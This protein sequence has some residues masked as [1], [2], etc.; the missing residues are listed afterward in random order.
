M[1]Y[2]IDSIRQVKRITAGIALLAIPALP[3]FAQT[4]TYPQVAVAGVFNNFDTFTPNMVLVA[5]NL[6]QADL[7][8]T[9]KFFWFKFAT[10]NFTQN[11]G[12]N[13]QPHQ[14][15][16]QSENGAASANDIYVTNGSDNVQFRFIFDETS[17]DY[18]VF[19]VNNIGSNLIYNSS[20]E[21]QGSSQPRAKYW[22][23]GNP[24]NHG[25]YS[26]NAQRQGS[27]WGYQVK[28]GAWLGLIGGT[29]AG[30]DNGAWWQEVPVEPGLTYEA[31]GWFNS[32]VGV[33][34]TW[35]TA[36]QQELKLE[37][38]NF[39]R[40]TLLATF[41]RDL[42]SV[43]NIWAEHAVAGLAPPGA[44]WAR[45]VFYATGVG[46]TGTLRMDD[47]GLRATV[48]KRSEDF[49]D[50]QGATID[51]SYT[52][53]GWTLATGRTVTAYIYSN[54]SISLARSGYAAS[55]SNPT[56]SNNGSFIQT[57]RFGDGVG[58]IS[59][60]YRH[61]YQG[62][63]AEN[64]DLPVHFKVQYS[65][66]GDSWVTIAQV[67]NVINTT[68]QR[69]DVFNGQSLARYVR[70][71]HSGGSTNRLL[72]DDIFVDAYNSQPRLMTFNSW[73]NATTV[74]NHFHLGWR[75]SN[76]LASASF[77]KD[78]LTGQIAG[79][80]NSIYN[81]LTPTFNNGYG[82]ISFDYRLGANSTRT[83]GFSLEA[84]SNGT[85]WAVLD[86]VTNI[87]AADWVTYNKFFIQTGSRTIR[88]RN[89]SETNISPNNATSINENFPS[90]PTPPSGWTF[91]QIGVYSGS[92]NPA[93]A[94]RLDATGASVTTPALI[95]PTNLLFWGQGQSADPQNF[96]VIE[97]VNNGAWQ[98]ITVLSNIS[99]S[100]TTYNFN[101]STNVSQV[102][103]TY[104]K[105][106][107]G[108]FALDNVRITGLGLPPPIPP[109][110]LVLENVNIG[111]P[112]EYRTQNFDTWPFKPEN[113]S[114]TTFYQ[115]WTLDGPVKIT[116]NKA[117]SGQSATFTRTSTNTGG[118]GSDYIADMEGAGETKT[119]YASGDVSLS[120]IQWNLTE[121]LIGT[122]ASD[123]FNGLR[124]IRMRGYGASVITMV[125][126]RPGGL[127]KLS[128]SYRRYGSDSQ[129]S[130]QAQYSTNAGVTWVNAGSPFTASATVQTFNHTANVA[131]D[132]RV[133][134]KE[135][136]GTGASNRRM[137]IDDIVI[138]SLSSGGG[139]G[140]GD[141]I[142]SS[143]T[144]HL[145]P[146]GIG[147]FSFSYRHLQDSTPTGDSVMTAV[148]QTSSNGLNWV[149][150]ATQSIANTSYAIFEKYLNITNHYYA[151]ILFSNGTS[152]AII[153]DISIQKPSPPASVSING[154]FAPLLPFTNDSVSLS[155]TVSPLYGARNVS[156]TS[157][158]RIG[159]SGAFNAITMTP[160]GGS[161]YQAVSNIPPQS[162]GT[163]VQF[164]ISA[165]FQGPGS[166]LTRPAT[167]PVNAPTN[168]AFYAIP[169]T[170][171]R[172][173]WINEID[174]R[175]AFAVG[176]ESMKF[177]EFV[178]L[179]G[180]AGIDLEGWSIELIRGSDTNYTMYGKYYIT[181]SILA[182]ETNGYGFFVL[183]QTNIPAPPRDM[184]MTNI[185]SASINIPGAIRLRN[186][187]GGLEDSIS[188][189]GVV[190]GFP[191]IFTLDGNFNNTQS[192]SLVGTG[193]GSGQFTWSTN[194]TL[195]TA[196]GIN[197]GQTFGDPA[198]I[199]LNTNFLEFR[200]IPLSFNPEN[201]FIIVSNDGGSVMSYTISP[202]VGWLSVSPTGNTNLQPGAT[203]THTVSVD[204]TGISAN[205][206]G[207]LSISGG[208]LNS[209]QVVNV[210]LLESTLVDALV[211]YEFNEGS[212]S[213]SLNQGSAG[214]EAN[215]IL[216]NGG[217]TL[218]AEG[219]S[220]TL[221]DFAYRSYR[222]DSRVQTLGA[223]TSLNN[224]TRFTISGWMQF[225]NATGVRRIIG[226]RS[227][228]NGFDLT[229][230]AD[231]QNLSLYSANST[232]SVAVTSTNG[233]NSSDRW[234]F[235][236]VTFDST[237]ES[238]SAVK[239]YSGTDVN[240]A[241]LQSA[242]SKG[243]LTLSGIST[244]RLFVGG[245]GTNAFQGWI[246]DVRVY[247][248]VL[249]PM[250][251]EAV[252]REGAISLTGGGE[253]PVINDDPESQ[254]VAVSQP[255]T[256]FVDAS[257]I[258]LPQ[259]QWRKFGNNLTNETGNTLF[260]ATTTQGDAGSYDVVVFNAY[261][262]VTSE[263]ATLV[264]EGNITIANQP[265]NQ[266]AYLGDTVSFTVGVVTS[267]TNPPTYQWR[268]NGNNI[269][270]A[271]NVFLVV[272]NI[273]TSDSGT[274]GFR[275][276][277]SDITGSVTS[278][279]ATITIIDLILDG[280]GGIFKP[281]NATNVV[282]SWPSLSGRTYDV[283]W[284]TNLMLGSHAFT[285]IATNLPAMPN[286]NIYTD[287]VHGSKQ[288]GFY[289]IKSTQQIP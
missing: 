261:G 10:P 33:S 222:N 37:F 77:A 278:S 4:S 100:G 133:R 85:T 174:Y 269:S 96:V 36:A 155:A 58:T 276:I 265:T 275:V 178:E 250:S 54:Q 220:S 122:S 198:I 163:I 8:I 35:K 196:G 258:P 148:V 105:I 6:W 214:S 74:A 159:T 97:G 106:A 273:S 246:D 234:N 121:A 156:V 119:G 118:S 254:S 107:G 43:T 257:G 268:K 68:Y 219:A 29:W 247:A 63:P 23:F 212:G 69:F 235:F 110:N 187:V 12:V 138:T 274:N 137:N 282:I 7:T 169:R 168:L 260:I 1:T 289:R 285:T 186:E 166:E 199:G 210:S 263:F 26:A 44:A 144:S 40:S 70:I 216:T 221:G 130:W 157:Y 173:V 272:N 25:S 206:N 256:F 242:L 181:N 125:Q 14:T 171:S 154:T 78:G 73:S 17:R 195:P 76:G 24:N 192:I 48:P 135:N 161:V 236:A 283:L 15:L 253:A 182:N 226:N 62:N 51:N 217:W 172:Q 113:D 224:L 266:I 30:S 120:G 208:A 202:N 251:V 259:Y 232:S 46:G 147:T 103:F 142:N 65:V 239:F 165:W 114:G 84:S 49:N 42:A 197:V 204:T 99:G 200:Y 28:S 91:N 230:S 284:M 288:Q 83:A 131:G 9:N 279:F 92:G 38:Y 153:D 2:L 180:F 32:E 20:F 150:A 245:D 3:V 123:W 60:Y 270:N 158:Y 175:A 183:A 19:L 205:R 82:T 116:T 152:S 89:L 139:G 241:F 5:D 167:Y 71:V 90:A 264:I 104:N 11:W 39:N 59:F 56:V 55:L 72:I 170:P 93:P 149:T 249:D 215:G 190:L 41:T 67:S 281:S 211:Y 191:R 188:Y 262:S 140:G 53:G 16:P 111:N 86:T 64:P 61:G 218:E 185:M 52:R 244:G 21:I 129:T 80:S 45:L 13:N 22:E 31:T 108:N 57:P 128:F 98:Q 238:A 248:D 132:I 50:W 143:I 267:T 79:H 66:L 223:V 201:Q 81:L 124:S 207:A 145:L 95:N 286:F 160:V 209:P 240:S 115:G 151:R 231:Y 146:D 18:A 34:T 176:F 47:A 112:L 189:G 184:S 213:L 255:V 203:F 162:S 179:A 87:T 194:T 237:N 193:S 277:A 271:T 177:Y 27:N 88:I 136:S 94:L 287:T 75:L 243:L 229:T 252:R 127:G 102:R 109:M 117:L 228:S 101:I 233:A 164:Y 225:T 227:T 126:S 280:S 141:L 134:I